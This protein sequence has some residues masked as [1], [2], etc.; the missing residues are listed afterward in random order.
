MF[1]RLAAVNLRS[2][3]KGQESNVSRRACWVV[4]LGTDA[5]KLEW[6]ESQRVIDY[7][8]NAVWLKKP[9]FLR[10]FAEGLGV[11]T[12]HW[13]NALDARETR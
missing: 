5:G 6:T 8:A 12:R 7:L 3:S 13:R 9:K 4:K 1:P 10:L 2:R 11:E